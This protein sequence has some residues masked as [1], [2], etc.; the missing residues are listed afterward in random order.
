MSAPASDNGGE[1]LPPALITRTSSE[2]L[3]K[4]PLPRVLRERPVLF[5]LGPGGVGKTAVARKLL[6]GVS[7]VVEAAFR[8]AVVQAAGGAWPT[9]LREAP[10]LLFDNVDFLHNRLGAQR[11]LGALLRE[12]AAAGRRTVLCEGGPDGSMTLLYPSV[13]PN[14]RASVLLRFPVGRGRRTHVANRCLVRAL[15]YAHAREAVV[16]EPWSYELVERYLDGIA[17]RGP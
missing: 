9:A 10:G 2:L 15:P 16:M 13:A 5:V 7:G 12:R 3:G 6:E 17:A 14:L 4:R 1:Y 8:P 11:L